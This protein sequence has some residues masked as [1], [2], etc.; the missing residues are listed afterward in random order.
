MILLVLLFCACFNKNIIDTEPLH[1]NS[2]Y[3]CT[4]RSQH[5][6]SMAGGKF[7]YNSS[8]RLLTS[9]SSDQEK[10]KDDNEGKTEQSIS[11][12]IGDML[13]ARLEMSQEMK[14]TESLASSKNEI[15]MPILGNDGIYRIINEEQLRNFKEEH[16]DKLVFLKFSSP[17]CKAC[18][19]L[20]QKFQH[21]H[22]SPKFVGMPVVFAEIVISNNK[23]VKD[24]FRDY[25]ITQLQV[26]RVPSIDFYVGGSDTHVDRFCCDRG[27]GCSWPKIQQQMLQSVDQWTTKI[28]GDDG[29]TEHYE[30][31]KRKT[32]HNSYDNDN[33]YSVI[34]EHVG[35]SIPSVPASMNSTTTKTTTMLATKN[36]TVFRSFRKR[37]RNLFVK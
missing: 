22:R 27:K 14:E 26:E 10:I 9:S 28:I 15:N 13:Q 24:S 3:T 32:P 31:L 21:L 34:E 20:K 2:V 4:K 7:R 1:L 18:R 12:L 30:V 23:K 5:N 33:K 11:G 19:M 16:S 25:I 29:V 36:T 8:S 35:I 37:I 17:I 6:N